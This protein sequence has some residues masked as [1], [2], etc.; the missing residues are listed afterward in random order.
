M[1]LV[2]ALM[3]IASTLSAQCAEWGYRS[4]T[5]VRMDTRLTL[6]GKVWIPVPH[7]RTYEERVPFCKRHREE[8]PA[9]E[10]ETFVPPVPIKARGGIIYAVTAPKGRTMEAITQAIDG[11]AVAGASYIVADTG[12]AYLSIKGVIYSTITISISDP[13]T[14]QE[15]WPATT[16]AEAMAAE[17]G[18]WMLA[19]RWR[20][21]S[22]GVFALIAGLA[23][24][25]KD[26]EVFTHNHMGDM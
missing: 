14:S 24:R 17:A 25:R 7:A 4:E 8:R 10:M 3:V 20:V 16:R 1:S 5:R 11:E 12:S 2:W 15:V 18:S 26:D 6:I 9:V 21:L 23:L 13:R 19:N 22:A